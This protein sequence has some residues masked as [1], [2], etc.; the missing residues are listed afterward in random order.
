MGKIYCLTLFDKT[1]SLH[2]NIEYKENTIWTNWI[3]VVR[4]NIVPWYDESGI[5]YIGV[6]EFTL[7]H[8]DELAD[9]I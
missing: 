9:I 2:K 1:V 7:K 6:E 4:D 5:F 8:I 3:V